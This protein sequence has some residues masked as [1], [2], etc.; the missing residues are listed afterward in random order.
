MKDDATSG[1]NMKKKTQLLVFQNINFILT[2]KM[3]HLIK[4]D[5]RKNIIRSIEENIKQLNF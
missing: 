4:L 2:I 5:I 1:L 3:F